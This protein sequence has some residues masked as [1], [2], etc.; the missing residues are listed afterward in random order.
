MASRSHPGATEYDTFRALAR[1]SFEDVAEKLIKEVPLDDLSSIHPA[2]DER[3]KIDVILRSC[4]WHW[5]DFWDEHRF[6]VTRIPRH[7]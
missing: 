2:C 6:R 3:P 1:L 5:F 4:H 7:I